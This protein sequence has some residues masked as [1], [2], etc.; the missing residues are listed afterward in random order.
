MSKVSHASAPPSVGDLVAQHRAEL[1]LSFGQLARLLGATSSR[2]TSRLSRRIVRIE[3]EGSVLERRLI[4]RLGAVLEIDKTT[5]EEAFDA[6]RAEERRQWL[7]WVN[8]SVPALLHIRAMPTIWY[9]REL[10]HISEEAATQI[11]SA[12]AKK[13]RSSVC[14]A[15]NR[16]L[17]IWFDKTGAETA[18][19]EAGPSI[20]SARLTTCIE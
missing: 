5:L 11:A 14:L 4:F 3:R 6:E 2:Q 8:E 10:G 9:T 18:R 19:T 7:R 20:P 16:K 13:E 1:Q 17:S 15:V 12:Y